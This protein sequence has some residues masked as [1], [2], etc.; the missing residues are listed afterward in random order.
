M[1][2]IHIADFHL[3]SPFLNL[4][5]KE[6]LG[7]MCRLK[8]RKVFKKIIEFIKEKNIEYLF[9]SGDLYE[10]KYI[11]KTTIEYINNL[12]KQIPLTQI[13]IAPGNHDPYIKNSYYNKFKWNENVKIFNSNIEKIETKDA[14]IY[15][16]GFDDFICENSKINDVEIENKG[17][18]NILIVH[19]DLDMS[20]SI[21]NPLSKK[22]LLDKGF[23]Y[24]ALGHIHK[25]N[26][27]QNIVYPGS[28]FP[29]GFDEIG[30]RGM[31]YGEL[32]NGKLTTE[33]IK[34]N[35]I[36]FVEKEIDVT[37][38]ISKEELI[39]KITEIETDEK[40]LIKINLIG[41]RNFEIDVYELYKWIQ[42]EHII[43]IKDK[44]EI[45][46][47]LVKLSNET[48]LRGIYIKQMIEKLEKE[49]DEDERKIIEKAIEIGLHILE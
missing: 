42:N 22:S 12:F 11:R 40:E 16:Y 46:Y 38:I 4:S 43:K 29:L 13:Y 26:C 45:N 24:I 2:F 41:K 15:G 17:K 39:E 30:E 19:G 37:K 8:Q 47:D 6:S 49:D 3:D 32:S 10:Q 34:L 1:K 44:T 31:V 33:F 23:D 14:D 20:Q 28:T 36:Y 21:Y 48:T 5:D 35:E 25:P 18:N 27:I 9:I 7:E